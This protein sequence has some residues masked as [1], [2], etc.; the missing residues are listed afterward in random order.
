MNRP[1]IEPDGARMLI[2][3]VTSTLTCS[4]VLD[5][6]QNLTT[7]DSAAVQPLK[8]PSSWCT[9]IKQP[10]VTISHGWAPTFWW[11]YVTSKS[12]TSQQRRFDRGV[13]TRRRTLCVTSSLISFGLQCR[14]I[15]WPIGATGVQLEE[16]INS[17]VKSE[18][19]MQT[20]LTTLLRKTKQRRWQT[21]KW[22]NIEQWLKDTDREK[23]WSLS[24]LRVFYFYNKTRIHRTTVKRNF[25]YVYISY[26]FRLYTSI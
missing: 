2:G 3:H 9:V 21:N 22:I 7:T 15:T 10:L 11:F 23:N 5:R 16:H 26:M 19:W 14:N 8:N 13:K 6:M 25:M 24:Q 12:M 20:C 18:E 4:I 1:A 17:L